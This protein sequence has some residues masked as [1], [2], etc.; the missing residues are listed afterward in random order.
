MDVVWAFLSNVS[1]GD[2]CR[3]KFARLSKVARLVLVL[4]YLIQMLVRREYSVW[5][6]L[7]RHPIGRAS[8]LMV[9]SLVLF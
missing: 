6:V 5:C 2:G 4:P 1:T 8:V 7:I 3:L 9:H